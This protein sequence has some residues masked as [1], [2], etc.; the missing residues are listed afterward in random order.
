MTE[1]SWVKWPY[2]RPGKYK[3]D[4]LAQRKYYS[5]IE[6]H[7]AANRHAAERIAHSLAREGYFKV[8]VFEAV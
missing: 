4:I 7:P 6:H 2:R 5:K 3:Y 8:A 1:I